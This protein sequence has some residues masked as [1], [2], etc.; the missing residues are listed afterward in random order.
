MT[1]FPLFLTK[2]EDLS[3]Y[4]IW[5]ARLAF[6]VLK[7]CGFQPFFTVWETLM[8]LI[9]HQKYMLRIR[10]QHREVPLVPLE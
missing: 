8:F 2:S 3:A 1:M 10:L 6:Q 7:S 9:L 4:K 5:V